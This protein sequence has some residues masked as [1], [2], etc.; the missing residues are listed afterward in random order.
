MNDAAVP[1]KKKKTAIPDDA[2]I[3]QKCEAIEMYGGS[4]QYLV[5]AMR[6][7][8]YFRQRAVPPVATLLAVSCC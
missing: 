1:I 2:P 8:N 3:P 6:P 7:G 5:Y 4:F